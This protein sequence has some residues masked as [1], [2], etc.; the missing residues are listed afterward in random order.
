M[1]RKLFIFPT[2]FALLLTAAGCS[3]AQ[4]E[5]EQTDLL[6]EELGGDRFCGFYVVPYR[7]NRPA[8]PAEDGWT[9][10][11]GD[12]YDNPNL[13]A[14][15]TNTMDIE[16]L[17][18]V[19]TDRQVLFAQGQGQG[20]DPVFPG[21]PEGY[22]VLIYNYT[23]KTDD[24]VSVAYANAIASNMGPGEKNNSFVSRDEGSEQT[25]SGTIYYGPPANAGDDWWE[26]Q[27]PG[28]VWRAYQVWETA[29]ERLYLDG[30]GDSYSGPGG[31]SF[32][33]T[34]TY[35]YSENGKPLQTDTTTVEVSVKVVPRLEHLTVYQYDEENTLLSEKDIPLSPELSDFRCEPGA[36]W[37]VVEAVNTNGAVH[38]AYDLTEEE[39]WHDVILLDDD[40]LGEYT[41]LHIL[42]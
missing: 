6:D 4:P 17:G 13:T 23:N 37:V 11:P 32:N 28:I 3:L 30:S 20:T 41:Q 27:D 36:A 8:E 18:S 26:L 7:D 34:H 15:G 9:P 22:Y 31:M 16:G 12:F 2:V 14:Y 38:T 10:L 42:P 19:E 29:D 35:T 40:G 24:G 33:Q 39:I 5:K 21:M 25:V 1:K